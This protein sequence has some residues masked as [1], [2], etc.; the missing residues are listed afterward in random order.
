MNQV[1]SSQHLVD[2]FRLTETSQERV[3]ALSR[4]QWKATYDF[5]LVNDSLTKAARTTA[6]KL[7]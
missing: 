5:L 4:Y 7:K 1:K 6:I 3:T 2:V